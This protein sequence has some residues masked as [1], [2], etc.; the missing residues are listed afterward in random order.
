M[1]GR[2]LSRRQVLR[3]AAT[4]PALGLAA[5]GAGPHA[6][7][8]VSTSAARVVP[9]RSADRG[10][11]NHGWLDTYHTF[12]FAGYHDPSFMQFGALRV[13]NQ[14]RLEPGR[15]FAMHGH[16]DMEIVSYVL[17]GT[18]EHKD[19]LGNGSRIRPGDVQFMSAGAGVRHSE[20]NASSSAGLHFLQMWILPEASGTRPRYAQQHFP[21]E[22][23][24]GELKLV[25]SPDGEQGSLVVGQDARLHVGSL[26]HGDA[27]RHVL[28][29]GRAA[30]VHV[31]EGS[32]AVNGVTLG[33][34]DGAALEGEHVELRGLADT[35]L[36]LWEVAA[37]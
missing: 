18:M 37:S 3:A 22:E 36:V 5:C 17:E 34:G 21:R 13:L 1:T 32:V 16:R 31:A 8:A 28:A 33:P 7:E 14:D 35:E 11:A 4:L 9:R 25:V 23:R 24:L 15:G 27:P 2:P 26:R 10:H 29:P 12:S 6:P 20:F 19:T 30:W